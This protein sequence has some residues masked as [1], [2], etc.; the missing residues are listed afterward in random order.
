MLPV[1]I[2]IDHTKCCFIGIKVADNNGNGLH[3]K[4]LTSG[5]AAV[6]RN[7]LIASAPWCYDKRIEDSVHSYAF[8]KLLH[9]LIIADLERLFCPRVY[10]AQQIILRGFGD[11]FF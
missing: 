7:D 11:S 3:A 5:I 4:L 2:G 8:Y 9:F 10:V 1:E 6:S